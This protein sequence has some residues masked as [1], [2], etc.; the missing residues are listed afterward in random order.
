MNSNFSPFDELQ[1]DYD[2]LAERADKLHKALRELAIDWDSK[3]TTRCQV[4]GKTWVTDAE[5]HAPDCLARPVAPP[6][7]GA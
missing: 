3:T 2:A 7:E 6:T 5:S 1:R 4:C